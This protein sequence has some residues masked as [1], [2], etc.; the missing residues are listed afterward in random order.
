MG[1]GKKEM[2]ITKQRTAFKHNPKSK[3]TAAILAMPNEGLCHTCHETIEW[4]KKYRRYKPLTVPG[5]CTNC[6]Q[7][8]VT[9][10]YHILCDACSKKLGQCGKCKQPKEIVNEIVTKETQLKE[11][12]QLRE[13]LK[14]MTERERRVFSNDIVDSLIKN[15]KSNATPDK[16]SEPVKNIKDQDDD[17]DEEEEDEENND[18]E[19]DGEKI[20]VKVLFWIS[21]TK[22][23]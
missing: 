19:L 21:V 17:D 11:E 2:I 23:K 3:K 6:Q 10:A 12:A 16:K 4:R 7:K 22:E 1:G 8:T 5:R 18:I 13:A 14:T 9:R 20:F 15:P